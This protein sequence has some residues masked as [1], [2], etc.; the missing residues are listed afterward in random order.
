MP[1]ALQLQLRFLALLV[2]ELLLLLLFQSELEFIF[3]PNI[4]TLPIQILHYTISH[5]L[6][7]KAADQ[8]RWCTLGRRIQV[9]YG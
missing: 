5:S 4:T 6:A 7:S 9:F 3:I 8:S 1:Q 2:L